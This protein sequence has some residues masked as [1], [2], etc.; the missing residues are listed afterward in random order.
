MCCGNEMY[1]PGKEG[2]EG[3]TRRQVLRA[4][5]AGAG[6]ITLGGLTG[7]TQFLDVAEAIDKS[8]NEITAFGVHKKELVLS[9]GGETL[10]VTSFSWK[11]QMHG[12]DLRFTSDRL[13]GAMNIRTAIGKGRGIT[14]SRT[15]GDLF[16]IRFK[17]I[18]NQLPLL[19]EAARSISFKPLDF[20]D[21][22]HEKKIQWL[23]EL[24][25][26]YPELIRAH[27]VTVAWNDRQVSL[28]RANSDKDARKLVKLLAHTR[29]SSHF[30]LGE[31]L[32]KLLAKHKDFV[33]RAAS[34]FPGAPAS[35]K[36]VTSQSVGSC[37]S[38][39][40]GVFGHFGGAYAAG[41]AC[42]T[43]V[44]CGLGIA[45]FIADTIAM[46]IS[47]V[48]CADDVTSDDPQDDPPPPPPPDDTCDPTLEPCPDS[49]YQG[50]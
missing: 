30:P 13:K 33:V 10:S 9:V 6:L 12:F 28:S 36:G 8:D 27:R 47:C 35:S 11:N 24:E 25:A 14:Y 22:E 7:C 16:T 19:N 42:A 50:G 18:P 5:G 39:G 15:K 46:A 3:L 41:A 29:G 45:L 32:H 1:E 23:N 37:I 17:V 44:L 40:I 43:G 4:M 38:C 31:S 20:L 21:N 49:I 34:M 26:K 48:G 2:R